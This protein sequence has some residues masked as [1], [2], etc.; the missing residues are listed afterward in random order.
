MGQPRNHQLLVRWQSSNQME[1]V[2]YL[3]K[4]FLCILIYEIIYF[5]SSLFGQLKSYFIGNPKSVA[6]SGIRRIYVRNKR[7]KLQ[8]GVLYVKT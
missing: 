6:N 3:T 8:K 2:L 5:P 4:K 7:F 1:T